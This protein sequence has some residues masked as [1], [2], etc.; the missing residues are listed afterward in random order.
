MA[1]LLCFCI[2]K[3]QRT[4]IHLSVE[5]ARLMYE[6]AVVMY[7]HPKLPGERRRPRLWASSWERF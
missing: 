1:L 2:A 7:P 4:G 3:A 5:R 6:C